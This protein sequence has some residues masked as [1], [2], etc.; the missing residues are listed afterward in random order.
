MDIVARIP[1]PYGVIVCTH[2]FGVLVVI[3]VAYD[4]SL[5]E[6]LHF[7]LRMVVRLLVMCKLPVLMASWLVLSIVKNM[8]N[9]SHFPIAVVLTTMHG[10][11]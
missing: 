3:L 8:E 10:S 7:V 11:R 5:E 4:V 2:A 1:V 6:H 9:Y